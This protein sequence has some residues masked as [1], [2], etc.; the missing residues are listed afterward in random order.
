MIEN[1]NFKFILNLILLNIIIKPILKIN[2]FEN[3]P[4]LIN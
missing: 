1:L 3:L 2:N 4:I